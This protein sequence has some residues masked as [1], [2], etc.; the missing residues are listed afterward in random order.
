M[1]REQAHQNSFIKLARQGIAKDD[2]L[3]EKVRIRRLRRQI[4]DAGL[5]VRCEDLYVTGTFRNLPFARTLRDSPLTQD[6]VIG[7]VQYLLDKTAT[8]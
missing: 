7:H 2:D 6:V 3:L 8:G 5:R 4:T 1:L